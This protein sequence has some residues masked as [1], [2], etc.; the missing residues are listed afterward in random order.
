LFLVV[1]PIRGHK[2]RRLQFPQIAQTTVRPDV[3]L[4]SEKAKKIILIE[5]TVLWEEGCDQAFE[6]ES[7]KYQE[8]S[9]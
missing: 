4:W 1:G 5:L 3:V 9:A 8:P 6:R 2:G 7:A